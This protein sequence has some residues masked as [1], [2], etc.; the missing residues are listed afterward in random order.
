MHYSS[1]TVATVIFIGSGA[2]LSEGC[3]LWAEPCDVHPNPA[4]CEASVGTSGAGGA[5]GPGS[6]TTGPGSSGSGSGAGGSGGACSGP[7]D[8]PNATGPCKEATCS[9]GV[10]GV[11]NRPETELADDKEGDCQVPSCINGELKHN[12]AVDPPVSDDPCMEYKCAGA[13]QV[14]EKPEG[15][16]KTVGSCGGDFRCDG[17]G[18][19]AAKEGKPCNMKTPCASGICENG[20]CRSGVDGPCQSQDHCEQ[21]VADAVCHNISGCYFGVCKV[22]SGQPCANDAECASN[23]CE[24]EKCE[25]CNSNADCDASF[26]CSAGS[27][28][29]KCT[30]EGDKMCDGECK[31]VDVEGEVFIYGCFP[32]CIW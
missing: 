8:C 4:M 25:A 11:K 18:K 5:G 23:K 10:C 2:L 30:G 1:T 19:C 27:C 17:K 15:Q 21:G 26:V 14:E 7:S 13:N 16:Y 12:L 6:T 20:T 24:Q 9:S 31:Q 22:T 29:P 32:P 28:L 3:G